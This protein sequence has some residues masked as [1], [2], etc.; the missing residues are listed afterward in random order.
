MH[1][2]VQNGNDL[3][4]YY[5]SDNSVLSIIM[6][7]N[8]NVCMVDASFYVDNLLIHLRIILKDCACN[9]ISSSVSSST[10][11]LSHASHSASKKRRLKFFL[12]KG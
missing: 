6:R 8:M 5:I 12:G 1:S 11:D 4:N 7:L 2:R 9:H 3:M 10:R